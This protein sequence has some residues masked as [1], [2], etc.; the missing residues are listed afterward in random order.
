MPANVVS[1]AKRA[2]LPVYQCESLEEVLAQ[3]DVLY[4]TRVQKERFESEEEWA[5]VKDSYRVDH[6]LL[7][8]A[9]PD[10]IIMH[11]LPRL[12]GTYLHDTQVYLTNWLIDDHLLQK[13]TL[14]LIS[15]RKGLFISDK[16]DMGYSYVQVLCFS[17]L[18]S[19]SML[20]FRSEWPCWPV[21]WAEMASK[22]HVFYGIW[23]IMKQKVTI[24]TV[25]DKRDILYQI[26]PDILHM[27]SNKDYVYV[28][29]M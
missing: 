19:Y 8:R 25:E 4:V 3:T 17:Y 5:R 13:L 28:E 18:L 10:M 24:I 14:R 7:S 2:R 26:F 21:W 11:P 16:W 9:K 15:I 20:C 27:D 29:E 23:R 22:V 6:A 12:A 1:F